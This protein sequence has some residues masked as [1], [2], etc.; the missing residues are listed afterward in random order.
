METQTHW[1]MYESDTGARSHKPFAEATLLAFPPPSLALKPRGSSHPRPLVCAHLL[2]WTARLGGEGPI[3]GGAVRVLG[4]GAGGR[5]DWAEMP[6][7]CA[8]A[9]MEMLS[10][11]VYSSQ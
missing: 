11:S 7:S 6:G 10:Y 5:M 8:L 9:S 3:G 4:F 2:C 1:Y